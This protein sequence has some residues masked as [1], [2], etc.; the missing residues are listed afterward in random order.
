MRLVFVCISVCCQLGNSLRCGCN[1]GTAVVFVVNYLFYSGITL[2]ILK[3]DVI[4]VHSCIN[5][6]DN[7]AFACIRY[8]EGVGLRVDAVYVAYVNHRT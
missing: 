2:A 1:G 4:I 8:V 3:G 5:N 6:A 7:Y